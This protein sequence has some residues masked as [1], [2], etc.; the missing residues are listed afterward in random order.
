MDNTDID[1]ARLTRTLQKAHITLITNPE[2]RFYASAVMVGESKIVDNCPTA[3]TDGRNKYYGAKFMSELTLAEIIGIV[4]HENLHVI[5]KHMIRHTDLM[6]R[7]PKTTNAAM[8]YV[9]ND[10]IHN[11]KGY[12]DWI[13]LPEGG[14]WDAKF[15]NWSV[16]EVYNFLTKGRTPEGD[17]EEIQPPDNPNSGDEG[18][19]ESDGGN[20]PGGKKKS[21]GEPDSVTIG[22]REYSLEGMDEHSPASLT[23]D[24]QEKLAGE[25]NEA[26]QQAATLAGVLGADLPRVFTEAAKPDI[27]WREEVSQFFSEFTK[28]TED[29]SWRRY[30]RRRLADDE[31]MPSRFNERIEELVL[32]VDASGSMW[33]ELF[34]KACNAVVDAVEQINPERV[35]VMFWDTAI[36]S[37]QVFEDNYTGV[38]DSLKPRGGG[39]TRAAC[40]VEHMEKKGY[41]PACVVM[42]TDGYLEHDLKWE[43]SIPTLWLVLE[44]EQF[45][46]P[47]GRKVKVK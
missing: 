10:M 11:V 35:R 12:G 37:D 17:E 28:G 21:K 8:D 39:G 14:L 38:R 24:E 22:G 7:D 46:P 45:A 15:H 20:V 41:N 16:M 42:I 23:P 19:E 44:S 18:D 4:L 34:N 30:D 13:A 32:A 31:L 3:C 25:I 33:G 6:E 1:I 43:T 26:I 29:Y 40:V 27:D 2:T 47:R 36:C 5:L 9:V